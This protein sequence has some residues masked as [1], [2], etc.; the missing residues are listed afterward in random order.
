MAE[1]SPDSWELQRTANP[2]RIVSNAR[3]GFVLLPVTI[4][5]DYT[6]SSFVTLNVTI[7][8]HVNFVY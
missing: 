8:S 7:E 6:S 2:N 5:D 1:K 3:M 4:E